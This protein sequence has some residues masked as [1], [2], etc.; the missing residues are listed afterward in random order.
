MSKPAACFY[1][2][3]PAPADFLREALEGLSRRPRAIAPKFFYDAQGSRLF[4]R[5]CQTPEYYL[6]RTERL[7]LKARAAEVA[8]LIG[9][10]CVLVEPGSGSCDKVRLLLEALCPRAYVPIDI[11]GDYLRATADALA[12][13]YPWLEVHAA[14]ADFTQPI[15]LPDIL[16]AA[17]G[18]RLAF[19]PGSSIGNFHPA[20]ARAFLGNL[21]RLVGP[22]GALLIGVDLKKEASVLHAA[23]NDAEGVTAAF[24]LNL[25]QRINRE[26]EG[27]FV[28]EAFAHLAF[29]APEQGRVEMHL[30]SRREQIV[31]VAGHRFK[32]ARGERLHTECSYKYA[33]EEFQRLAGCAGLVARAVW[34]DPERLFSLH[35]LQVQ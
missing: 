16:Q 21:A 29:Y 18:R 28:P 32:F 22:G 20:Q 8:A 31:T 3:H 35:Y 6:T 11:S 2:N 34:T 10:E 30:V 7:L 19:F 15:R 13:D 5:I 25:L 26:L 9:P 23:Y 12:R 27:N 1:D 24:N 4:E 14:C 33:V 17:P